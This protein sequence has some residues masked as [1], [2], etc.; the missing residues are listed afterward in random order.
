M[1]DDLSSFKSIAILRLDDIGDHVLGSGL[2]TAL[3]EKLPHAKITV[4]VPP[5]SGPLYAACPHIDRCITVPRKGGAVSGSRELFGE[6]SNAVGYRGSFDL[7]INPRFATDHY[8]ASVFARGLAARRSIAF[9][10]GDTSIDE[11][12]TD[13]VQVPVTNH[14]AHY[15]GEL[16][17]SMFGQS[18][19]CP[20]ELWTRRIDHR[21]A[22]TK[23]LRKGWDGTAPLVLIAPG[24]SHPCRRWPDV[25]VIGLVQALAENT[26]AQLVLIGSR[27]ERARFPLL[28]TFRHPRLIDMRG[29][30]T[31]PQLAACCTMATLFIGTD[32]GPKHVA[33]AAGLTVVEIN[34]LPARM[35][36]RV[37]DAWPTG[38]HWAAYGV[39]TVQIQPDGDLSI[40]DI[41][42]GKSIASVTEQ[43]VLHEICRLWPSGWTHAITP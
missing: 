24:A 43:Q 16:M 14:V 11:C 23:L 41:D 18:S 9:R 25:R 36:Q 17:R 28:K 39:Q 7:L 30:L 5:A 1:L 4:F 6:G 22:G 38:T 37:R 32:S 31:L 2:I 40:E 13:L 29:D 19:S 27:A 12:Y 35:D 34:H 21:W 10:Q 3:R 20:P 26:V 42:S 8:G 15:S 33:A